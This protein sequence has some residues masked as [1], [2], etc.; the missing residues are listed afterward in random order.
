LLE[1]EYVKLDMSLIRDV[2]Q[3]AT[4]QKIIRSM[5]QLS[6]DMGMKVVAEGIE[7]PEE[8]S[9]LLDIGCDLFQGFLFARPSPT[10]PKVEW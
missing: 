7:T 3:N 2:D 8:L 4:R 6:R 10:F 9:T 1:P 5:T